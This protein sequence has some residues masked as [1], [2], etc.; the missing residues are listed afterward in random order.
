MAVR[1]RDDPDVFTDPEIVRA[2]IVA[3]ERPQ[4]RS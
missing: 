3:E 1:G 4:P 2:T